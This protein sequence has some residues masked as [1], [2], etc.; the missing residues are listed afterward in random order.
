MCQRFKSV[1]NQSAYVLG[2]PQFD[3]ELLALF[4]RRNLDW[5]QQRSAHS[6]YESDR[7]L[8]NL[9]RAMRRVF[10]ESFG[11]TSVDAPKHLFACQKSVS[12]GRLHQK[13][14]KILL[15]RFSILALMSSDLPGAHD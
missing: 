14:K 2:T 8:R 11:V 6:S 1:S 9:K 10:T 7:G 15:Y 5:R 3:S 4:R 12:D 13:W